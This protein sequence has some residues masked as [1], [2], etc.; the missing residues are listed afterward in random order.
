MKNNVTT[1]TRMGSFMV[2]SL[3]LARRLYRTRLRK[4]H[5]RALYE[6]FLAAPL[7]PRRQCQK[8]RGGRCGLP[9]D[10]GGTPGP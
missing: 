6:Q 8:K 9:A 2:I 3:R 7:P 10:A 1:T 4:S 5:I